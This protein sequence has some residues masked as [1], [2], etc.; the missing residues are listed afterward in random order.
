[1]W[2][3]SNNML[4]RRNMGRSCNLHT[5]VTICTLLDEPSMRSPGPLNNTLTTIMAHGRFIPRS[6]P[7]VPSKLHALG[8]KRENDCVNLIEKIWFGGL[9]I[10]LNGI[11]LQ[12]CF[13]CARGKAISCIV[14]IYGQI[15]SLYHIALQ[16]WLQHP[17]N[18]AL[19]GKK[20]FNPELYIGLRDSAYMN[21]H[22][23]HYEILQSNSVDKTYP[24]LP[25]D[26]SMWPQWHAQRQPWHFHHTHFLFLFHRFPHG[27]R[28]PLGA[29]HSHSWL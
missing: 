3:K 12:T 1:M 19:G 15:L 17:F 16:T 29:A 21:E 26:N 9:P 23:T 13:I 8:L 27:W 25:D 20:G 2:T 11:L 10:F 18:M 6:I 22:T 4:P 14:V 5:H 24:R 7:T 28:Q